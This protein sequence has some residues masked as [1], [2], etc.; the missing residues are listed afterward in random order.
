LGQFV[1]VS[2]VEGSL[3]STTDYADIADISG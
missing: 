2:G 1:I 3:K